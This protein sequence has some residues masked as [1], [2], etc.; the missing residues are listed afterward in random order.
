MSI[1]QTGPDA[2]LKSHLEV[3]KRPFLKFFIRVYVY[4]LRK[5]IAGVFSLHQLLQ[6]GAIDLPRLAAKKQWDFADL[7]FFAKSVCRFFGFRD[8]ASLS[9]TFQAI[10]FAHQATKSPF[11]L[12]GSLEFEEV[13]DHLPATRGPPQ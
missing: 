3:G 8:A 4:R 6:L 11:F 5:Y 12:S 2:T 7:R 13:L 9:Q 10:R 1:N